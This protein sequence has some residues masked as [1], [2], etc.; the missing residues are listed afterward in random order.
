MS[1]NIKTDTEI[2]GEEFWQ[3]I[4]KCAEENVRRSREQW[5]KENLVAREDDW[6]N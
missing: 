3:Q 5:R 4:K 2:F 6:K 1:E